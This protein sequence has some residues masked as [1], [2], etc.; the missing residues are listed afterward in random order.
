MIY[1]ILPV[2]NYIGN[3]INTTFDFDFYIENG[4]QLKVYHFNQ[5]GIKTLLTEGIDYSVNEFKNVNGSYINFPIEGSEYSILQSN[6]K[7]SLELSLTA[8]QET[9]YNNSSLLNLESL[10]Y[11]LDYLTRLIQILA[12]K[13]Q[14]CVK[15]EECS[16]NTPEELMNTLNTQAAS[17]TTAAESVQSALQSINQMNTAITSAY[18]YIQSKE[19]KYDKIDEI[20][21]DL[22]EVVSDV[23]TKAST[24]LS[25]LTDTGISYATELSFPLYKYEKIGATQYSVWTTVSQDT[26][27]VVATKNA[28]TSQNFA[29]A[30]L[31]DKGQQF[32]TIGDNGVFVQYQSYTNSSSSGYICTLLTF[33][34]KNYS[35]F[36]R[37]LGSTSFVKCIEYPMRGSA[38]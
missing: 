27:L 32:P 11:S 2:N 16:D 23:E 22:Q 36:V 38:V 35:Y 30:I 14:L 31:D 1:D 37:N 20:E 25:N 7:I 29:V 5:N 18:N 24:D 19:Y 6:E 26:M 8:S 13:I 15:V 34:P 33:V 9:Q 12:R 3:N 17:A 4:N 10:E 28:G 21:S